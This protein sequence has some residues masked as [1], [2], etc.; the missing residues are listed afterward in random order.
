LLSG[1][2][3]EHAGPVATRHWKDLSPGTRRFVLVAGTVEGVLKIAALLDLVQRPSD[4]VRGS[5]G[6][7]AAAIVLTNS[8]GAVPLAYFAY[9]RR[10]T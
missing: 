4:E 3:R 8:L 2:C 5:K 6:R 1:S 10:R 7:W 9:G